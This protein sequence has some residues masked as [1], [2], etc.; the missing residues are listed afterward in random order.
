MRQAM[1]F[2]L[3]LVLSASVAG[4]Q[5][6]ASKTLD[7][8]VIDVEG[9]NLPCFFVSP[10]GESMLV[11]TGNGGDGA[12][13]DAGRII[14]AVKD[15]GIQQIDHLII[16][17]Y[18]GDHIGGLSEL[19]THIPIKEFIDHGANTQPGPNIDPILQR[20]AELNAK[21][22]HRVVK[23]GDKIQMNGLDWR[24]VSAG[25]RSVEGP[26]SRGRCTESLL[27]QFQDDGYTE[28]GG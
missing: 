28:D 1:L 13:R 21:A 27:H 15:S 8:Y 14:A 12:V 20:Y 2:L 10:S 19:A 26:A 18:H 3:V 24:I 11:D 25:E 23:P 7:I 6:R 16:T 22:K 9:G 4:A 5:N 17:H